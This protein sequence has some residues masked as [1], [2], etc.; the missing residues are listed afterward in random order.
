MQTRNPKFWNKILP[1]NTLEFAGVTV[2]SHQ[3]FGISHHFPFWTPLLWFPLRKTQP[4]PISPK[5]RINPKMEIFSSFMFFP[6]KHMCPLIKTCKQ[7][8]PLCK[9]ALR[10]SKSKREKY[11]FTAR[12]RDWWLAFCAPR[13][14][15]CTREG[16]NGLMGLKSFSFVVLHWKRETKESTSETER[17]NWDWAVFQQQR[18]N[19]VQVLPA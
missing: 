9:W 15:I 2:T 1:A 19:A 3:N 14:W 7:T 12:Q 16:L 17:G 18:N 10:L 11:S 5:A 13:V 4:P 6:F 8:L